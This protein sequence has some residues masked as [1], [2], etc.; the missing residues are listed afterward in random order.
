[1]TRLR[2]ALAAS[3]TILGFAA[4]G[5]PAAFAQMPGENSV[6]G[7]GATADGFFTGIVVDAHSDPSGNN[8]SGSVSFTVAG[9]LN[10]GGNVTCLAID[11]NHAVIGFDDAMG[12]FGPITV[13][14][15]D[16][17]STGTPPDTFFADPGAT[18]C[19][20]DPSL[21]DG[22]PIGTGDLVVS[23]VPPL[24]S[25]EQC[26]HGGWRNFTDDQGQSFKNQGACI[27][28]VNHL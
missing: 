19:L 12:G 4:T 28:F 21:P 13:E 11:G 24:T 10:I 5:V 16:N 27:K 1:M 26:K 22:G 7:S 25:Q 8:V 9:A 14:I 3:L 23:Q 18:D 20:S 17:G 6:T 2:L 15:V